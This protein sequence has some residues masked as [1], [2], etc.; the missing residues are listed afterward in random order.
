MEF[1]PSDLSMADVGGLKNL[2][3]WLKLRKCAFSDDA[4][5]YGLPAP[6][7]CL[8]IGVS[9]GGK[10]LCAKAAANL[11]EIPLLRLDFGR[12]FGSLVGDS[13]KNSRQAIALA[14][15]ISPCV[16]GQT[17][18][19]V[20]NQKD[21]IENIFNLAE[22]NK[23]NEISV[24]NNENG[25]EV[26]R[27]VYLDRNDKNKIVGYKDEAIKDVK[28]KALIRTK[29]KEKLVKITTKSGKTIIVTKN[30]MLMGEENK[31]KETKEFKVGDRISIV[32]SN[33]IQGDNLHVK[34]KGLQE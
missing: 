12:L 11:F 28:L 23:N 9:G 8:A 19:T 1:F 7:G 33:N 15:A 27:V 20:N 4:S 21:M 25:E 30:H 31:M 14:E 29:K 32:D 10:S 6:R 26:Q 24:F 5:T 18:I 34:D 3:N 16:L 2:T 17:E 13:E 22:N